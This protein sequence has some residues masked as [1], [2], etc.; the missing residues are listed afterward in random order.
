VDINPS[1]ARSLE[2]GME[3]TLTVHRLGVGPLLRRTLASTNPIESCMST[4]RK[5]TRRVTRWQGGDH[6]ARWT[7]AG[8]LEAE[9]G[10]RRIK[11]YRELRALV[12]KLNPSLQPQQEV[13]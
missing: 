2:E 12:Q 9:K 10:F 8:L 5:V 4:V 11:G 6:I 1:A 3:E 13:A 7:A